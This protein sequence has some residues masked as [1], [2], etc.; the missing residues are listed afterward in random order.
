MPLSNTHALPIDT[1]MWLGDAGA[2]L[3]T[4]TVCVG[5][6]TTLGALSRRRVLEKH[7]SRKIMHIGNAGSCR[8]LIKSSFYRLVLAHEGAPMRQT[9]RQW[10]ALR[11]MLASVFIS[12]LC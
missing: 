5:Y 7:L 6:I 3:M 10:A 8:G 9:C 4:S 2:F 1:E 12:T 11:G